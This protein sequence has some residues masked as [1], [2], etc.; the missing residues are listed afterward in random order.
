MIRHRGV[1]DV[2]HLQLADLHRLVV[3]VAFVVD[4]DGRGRT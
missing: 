3:T 4:D 1:D 2:P